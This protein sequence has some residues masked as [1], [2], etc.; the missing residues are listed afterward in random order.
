ME[1]EEIRN[2]KELKRIIAL[3]IGKMPYDPI[4]DEDFDMIEE[5]AL[6]SRLIN[7]KESGISL[8]AIALFRNLRKLKL[9]NYRITKEAIGTMASLAGL[10]ELEIFGAE[11]EEGIS[12]EALEQVLNSLKF[13]NCLEIG[14]QY[15]RVKDVWLNQ[16][17]IDFSKIDLQAARKIIIRNGHIRNIHDLTDFPNIETVNLDG[18]VLT[19]S[20]NEKVDDINVNSK[21]EYTHQEEVILTNGE[22]M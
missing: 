11:F 20:N 13:Y 14:F 10:R 18:S 6:N 3:K 5:I 22:R 4:S 1:K 7:G 17:D 12:F 19:T 8:D 16:T 21:T 15:P 9:S 2:N